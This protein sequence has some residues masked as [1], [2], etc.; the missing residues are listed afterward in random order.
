M[1]ELNNADLSGE[2]LI[3]VKIFPHTLRRDGKHGVPDNKKQLE[4]KLQQIISRGGQHAALIDG[5][6]VETGHKL[7]EYLIQ[8]IGSRHVVLEKSD[9][10]QVTL[11]LFSKMTK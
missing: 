9:G 3:R 6:R 1:V 4:L 2:V 10:S 11:T 7:G 8:S 5:R